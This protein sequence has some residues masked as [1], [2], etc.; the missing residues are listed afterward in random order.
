MVVLAPTNTLVSAVSAASLGFLA[1]L[2]VIG[3]SG[4]GKYFS[5]HDPSYD[6]LGCIGNGAYGRSWKMFN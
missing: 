5:R 6:I 1:V 3:A 2:G 4:R